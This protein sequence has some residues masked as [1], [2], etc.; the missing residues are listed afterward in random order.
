MGAISVSREADDLGQNRGSARFCTLEL[1]Q[2]QDGRAF[3]DDKAVAVPV[4]GAR[5]SPRHIVAH[6]GGVQRVEDGRFG[7]DSSSAPPAI[8]T[9]ACP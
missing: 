2:H 5:G 9:S 7:G 6:A 1:L 8:I 4:E 3:A